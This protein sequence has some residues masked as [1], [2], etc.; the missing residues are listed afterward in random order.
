MPI[1]KEPEEI[2]LIEQACNITT[3][4]FKQTVPYIKPGIYEY[5]IEA[6]LTKIL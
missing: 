6:L 4:A 3:N 2:A 1:T 5:E